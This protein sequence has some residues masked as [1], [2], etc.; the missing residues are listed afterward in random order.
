MLDQPDYILKDIG[1]SREEIVGKA[2]GN[3]SGGETGKLGAN[4]SCRE[5]EE[6]V[7]WLRSCS[8]NRLPTLRRSRL[9]KGRQPHSVLGTL[10]A[11]PI[12]LQQWRNR[13]VQRRMLAGMSEYHLK[14]IGLS[15]A[16]VE[17]E[18]AKHFW[19]RRSEGPAGRNDDKLK[20]SNPR[21]SG[22]AAVDHDEPPVTAAP[23][24][25]AK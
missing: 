6:K 5:A 4:H 9:G 7:S 13:S 15:R 3:R 11:L 10:L 8:I 22:G 12:A 25:V 24:L 14:D 18:V 19:Q 2:L 21:N 20:G 1:V 17:G 16:D 23:A